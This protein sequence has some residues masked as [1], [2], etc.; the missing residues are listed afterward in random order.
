[1]KFD[2]SPKVPQSTRYDLVYTEKDET[3]VERLGSAPEVENQFQ[4]WDKI[5]SLVL[6]HMKNE[7]FDEFCKHNNKNYYEV[8]DKYARLEKLTI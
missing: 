6:Q 7:S 2:R 5:G 8:K 4:S 1:M 3:E